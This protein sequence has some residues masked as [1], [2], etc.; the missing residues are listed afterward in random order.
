M[1]VL[2]QTLLFTT[3]ATGTFA[4]AMKVIQV[5][6]SPCD[7]KEVHE[8]SISTPLS[9]AQLENI[10]NEMYKAGNDYYIIVDLLKDGLIQPDTNYF[11]DISTDKKDTAAKDIPIAIQQAYVE[12]W[13]QF[14]HKYTTNENKHYCFHPKVRISEQDLQDPSSAAMQI[15]KYRLWGHGLLFKEEQQ[16]LKEAIKDG[17]IK[18]GDKYGFSLDS[19]KI[20]ICYKGVPEQLREKY[21]NLFAQLLGMTISQNHT[22]YMGYSYDSSDK[23]DKFIVQR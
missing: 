6:P 14:V 19:K 17:I 18:Q 12:K 4:Q 15:N 8:Q 2:A 16:I 22:G 13:V 3:F 23:V 10:S 11:V 21:Y 1:K 5:P 7:V 20:T 9:K